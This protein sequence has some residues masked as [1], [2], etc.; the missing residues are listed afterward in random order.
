MRVWRVVFLLFVIFEKFASGMEGDSAQIVEATRLDVSSKQGKNISLFL[1]PR[2]GFTDILLA[3]LTL[4]KIIEANLLIEQSVNSK[5][6]T[7]KEWA[8]SKIPDRAYMEAKIEEK[9]GAYFLRFDVN[10]VISGGDNM[11]TFWL[12]VDVDRFIRILTDG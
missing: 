12:R 8:K 4:K 9:N 11:E 6:I 5:N 3:D 1:T 10:L 7:Y 2:N